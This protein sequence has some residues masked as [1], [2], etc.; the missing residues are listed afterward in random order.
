MKSK[1]RKILTN[2][3]LVLAMIV[4]ITA[5]SSSDVQAATEYGKVGYYCNKANYD[6]GKVVIG[7]SR[8][9]QLW[10]Q[11]KKGASYSSVWGG[12]YG[13]GKDL[14]IDSE[15]HLKNVKKYVRN[16]IKKTGN[17][18]VYIFATVNDYNGVGS[19]SGAI[20]NLMSL[21]DK[22]SEFEYKDTKPNIYIV[23]LKGSKGVSV[24]NYNKSLKS[25]V[26]SHGYTYKNIEKALDTK[27]TK[28]VY[29]SDDLHY[30]D[31]ALKNIIKAF[32]L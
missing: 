10:N 14:Q 3:C 11:S 25:K 23:S 7:D 9:C 16:T 4:G 15:S 28:N 24:S 21:A 20:N 31:T 26:K 32:D 19:Y 8:T 6:S 1:V 13:Y 12:H 29:L 5:S 2:I 27:N 17:C 22:V 30:N 18:D